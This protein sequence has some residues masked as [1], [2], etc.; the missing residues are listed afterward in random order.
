MKATVYHGPFKVADL[1]G[2]DLEIEKA[3]AG[4]E[5]TTV[6]Y[7]DEP[8][9]YLPAWLDPAEDLFVDEHHWRLL[10]ALGCNPGWPELWQRRL[11]AML[12]AEPEGDTKWQ[13]PEADVSACCSLLKYNGLHKRT[14]KRLES[15]SASLRWSMKD[16]LEDWLQDE[17]PSFDEALQDSRQVRA[18]ECRFDSPFSPKQWRKVIRGRWSDYG[19]HLDRAKRIKRQLDVLYQ[20]GDI[21]PDSVSDLV[22]RYNQ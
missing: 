10:Y 19:C 13:T 6:V 15:K 5:Y 7:E 8:G 14:G 17:R 2:S 1:E 18:D 9:G 3:L 11:L 4:L 21:W 22:L 20:A 12:K 16:Q